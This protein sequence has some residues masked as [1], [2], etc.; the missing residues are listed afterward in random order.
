MLSR[1]AIEM[2]KAC[3]KFGSNWLGQLLEYVEIN[4]QL[5]N[6]FVEKSSLLKMVPLE[7]TY[8]A[9]VEFDPSLGDFQEKLFDNGLHVLKGEQFM[10]KHF[11]RINLATT[12]VNVEKALAIIQKTLDENS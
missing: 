12:K 2:K 3:L 10:G 1:H 11:V 7:G 8:L 6:E 4:H 9:W 5:L